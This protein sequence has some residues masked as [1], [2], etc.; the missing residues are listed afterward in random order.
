MPHRTF[1]QIPSKISVVSFGAE[2]YYNF[3]ELLKQFEE[4]GT[5]QIE[6]C[7][8]SLTPYYVEQGTRLELYWAELHLAPPVSFVGK[9]LA[10]YCAQHLFS[11]EVREEVNAVALRDGRKP[12]EPGKLYVSCW[13]ID[14]KDFK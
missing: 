14:E 4:I 12:F 6:T 9:A 13:D 1:E 3:L 2:R 7:N 8:L 5:E 10:N 11:K